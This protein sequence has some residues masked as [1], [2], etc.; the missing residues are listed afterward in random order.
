M[1][2]VTVRVK[3][4]LLHTRTPMIP[5]MQSSSAASDSLTCL[6]GMARA[7]APLVAKTLLA[8]GLLCFMVWWS[9]YD[10]LLVPLPAE[11][12]LVVAYWTCSRPGTI[13][14]LVLDYGSLLAF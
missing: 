2:S 12:V 11:H 6:V 3:L 4:L 10:F 5:T 9:R 1:K 14:P 13:A 8:G 7:A